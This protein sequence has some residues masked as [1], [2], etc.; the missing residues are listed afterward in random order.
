MN[1]N[2]RY[3]MISTIFTGLLSLVL[4]AIP[5]T[6]NFIGHIIVGNLVQMTSHLRSDQCGLSCFLFL[7]VIYIAILWFVVFFLIK[8]LLEKIFNSSGDTFK[9]NKPLDI[10][11]VVSLILT[12]IIILYLRF[13]RVF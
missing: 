2:Q 5:T 12:V 3:I 1:K 4:A 6:K 13:I 9:Q 10:I 11:L 8:I 7:L